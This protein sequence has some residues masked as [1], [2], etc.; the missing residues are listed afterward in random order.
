MALEG[1]IK[2]FGLADIL[3]LIGLQR[4]TG[5]LRLEGGAESV[6]V[7]FLE[8]AI[9][10]ADT[11]RN[12]LEGLLGSV[13]V[14]TGR[15][16]EAQLRET[17][18]IQKST[19]RR[20]G[21]ILVKQGFISDVD[22][23]EALR[24]QVTQ[25]V[26]RLFRWRDGRYQF[27]AMDNVEYDREHFRPLSAETILMEG[28][29]MIDEWP[30][31]ERRIKSPSM[32]F[33]KTSSGERLDVPVASLLDADIDFGFH[34][35]P[36]SGARGEDEVRLSPEERDVLHM[37]D[38]SSAVQEIVDTSALSEFDIY[39]VLVELSNRHLIEEVVIAAAGISPR[40][41]R[42]IRWASAFL[43]VLVIAG[44]LT[45]ISTV[46]TNPFTP[47]R[48]AGSSHET[49]LLK[50]Y[51]SRNRIERVEQAIQA[52]YLDRGSMPENLESVCAGGYLARADL[53]DPWG[54]LYAYRLDA[55][56]FQV[57]GRA[58]EPGAGEVAIRH[59]FSTSQRMVLQGG[60]AD[61][62][63]AARP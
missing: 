2:D 39:R 53:Y 21:Y 33:R 58:P 25:I 22:L 14:R 57:V 17:L 41:D 44:A 20:V 42:R 48:L 15:I 10:G 28:A 50:T 27:T 52:Y 4:K 24:I 49:A 47:W 16:T 61:Q 63:G 37:V 60:A 30:I 40:D 23:E 45:G 18:Q 8:G 51:A 56:S 7:K 19:L 55:S 12:E 6:T 31:L 34:D 11:S 3:Q 46:G 43:Q 9:V 1:T 59:P 62:A 38:G 54:H 32:V 35:S 5:V 36:R 26:F 13:L 29:R